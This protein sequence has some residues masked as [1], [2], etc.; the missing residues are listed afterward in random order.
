MKFAALRKSS[1]VRLFPVT[2]VALIAVVTALVNYPTVFMRYT[3][4]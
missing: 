4:N 2:E 1:L 3:G